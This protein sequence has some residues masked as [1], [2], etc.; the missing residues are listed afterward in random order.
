MNKNV[1]VFESEGR[2]Y[3]NQKKTN[4]CP[5]LQCT[6]IEERLFQSDEWDE[7]LLYPVLSA[8][9]AEMN[10]KLSNYA[11]DHLPEGK[12][13]DPDPEVKAICTS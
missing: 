2:L 13:W 7:C 10:R 5:H 1:K 11:K 3:G 8:G 9:T 4:H 12:Y 6:L